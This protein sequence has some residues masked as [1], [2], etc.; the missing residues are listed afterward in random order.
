MLILLLILTSFYASFLKFH[1]EREKDI[2]LAIYIWLRLIIAFW[3]QYS[4]G[5]IHQ[6]GGILEK[7]KPCCI[8]VWLTCYTL[9]FYQR[10]KKKYISLTARNVTQL[11]FLFDS[12][13]IRHWNKAFLPITRRLSYLHTQ[14][15][16]AKLKNNDSKKIK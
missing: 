3:R 16:C 5:N 12:Q 14:R 15:F 13:L 1:T 4:A 11:F 6:I 10:T 7:K 2:Y 9:Y 8:I